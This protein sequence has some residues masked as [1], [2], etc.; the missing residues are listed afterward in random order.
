MEG[1]G[2]EWRS[3]GDEG[4]DKKGREYVS[5]HVKLKATGGVQWKP[6]IVETS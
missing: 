5:R 6:N 3:D 1:W 2:Q 4:E